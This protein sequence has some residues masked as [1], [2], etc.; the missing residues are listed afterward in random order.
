MTPL[1]PSQPPAPKKKSSS[2]CLIAVLVF[3]GLLGVVCIVTAV[4]LGRAAQT[5]E[6]KR[7]M[8]MVGKGVTVVTKAMN[9]PGAK[10]VREAGC[11]EAMV[12]D[13][14]EIGEAFEEFFD[15]GMKKTGDLKLLVMCQG[16]FSLP[17]CDEVAEAYRNAPGVKPGPFTVVVKK[18]NVK[19]NECERTY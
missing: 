7:V 8:S 1:P 13:T 6:G 2:G 12:L 17:T 11:P 10:E 9:A 3:V 14:A 19:Q 4:M 5:P 18:K 15:G 16:T